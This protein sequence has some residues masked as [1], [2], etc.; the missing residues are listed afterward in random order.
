[1]DVDVG[2]GCGAGVDLG[3]CLLVDGGYD[4]GQ[5]VCACRIEEEEGKAAVAGD[6]A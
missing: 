2:V 6:Q 4:Y 3:V 5:V 1:V